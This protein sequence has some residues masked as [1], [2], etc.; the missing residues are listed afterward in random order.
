MGATG[1][2]TWSKV[3]AAANELRDHWNKAKALL[4]AGGWTAG[5]R[6]NTWR[7]PQDACVDQVEHRVAMLIERERLAAKDGAR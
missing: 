6:P 5:V 7:D 4:V 1:E 2:T 3:E